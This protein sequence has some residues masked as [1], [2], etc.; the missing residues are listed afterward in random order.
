MKEIIENFMGDKPVT[1]EKINS[2][3]GKHFNVFKGDKVTGL[4]T[5]IG[6][7]TD[8]I[9]LMVLSHT[10]MHESIRTSPIKSIVYVCD[11]KLVFETQNSLYEIV[12]ESVD[13]LKEA[14]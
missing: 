12:K 5:I 2:L 13:S 3:N 7:S 10:R 14:A 4:G 11:T 8:Q 6:Y 9:A 1:L